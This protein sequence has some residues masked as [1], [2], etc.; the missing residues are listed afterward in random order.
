[1]QRKVGL[2]TVSLPRERVDLAKEFHSHAQSAFKNE[3]F[4]VC[5]HDDLVFDAETGIN[6]AERMK[7]EGAGCIFL[8]LGTW[9]NSPVIV[10][11]LR[12]VNIPFAIWAED[13]PASFSLTAGGI[14]HGALDELGLEHRFFYG[15]PSCP[16]LM[17]EVSAFAA[18]ACCSTH[19]EG[20]KLCVV[21]GRVP[22]MYTTMADIIQI[23]DVFGVEIEHLDSVKV[24]WTAE[25][26][27]AQAVARCKEDVLEQFG[28]V[29]LQDGVLDRSVRLYLALKELLTDRG[30]KMAAVKCMDEMINGYCSFCLAH[31]LLNDDGFTVSCE[32]DIY[33]ALTMEMLRYLSGG[34]VLFGD[35][36]HLDHQ[37][38]L[39]RIVNCGSMPS[40]MAINRK[41][42]DLADQ[43]DYLCDAGGSTTVFSV[44]DSPATAGRLFRIRGELGMVAFEGETVRKP[45][46]KFKEAREFWPHAFMK[47]DCDTHALVQNL[48]SNHMH[49][50]FGHELAAVRE[51]CALKGLP[52]VVPGT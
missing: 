36:N 21:G 38:R 24:F 14:V 20:Q 41:D 52:L 5:A 42:V 31:S 29:N 48:R 34:V 44:K 40:T 10:D 32:G 17:Q 23:K 26:F 2:I 28:K 51:F 33:A 47:V 3:A 25:A 30:Y 46:E 4:A 1:M 9:V 35:I 11:I 45:K 19:L 8:L 13:N 7:K 50:S 39:F 12:A 27:D 18:G 37:E 6:A 22:G 43:Y 16:D 49:V 15:S